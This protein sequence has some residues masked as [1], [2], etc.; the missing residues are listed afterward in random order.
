VCPASRRIGYD[1][2]ARAG[3]I[4]ALSLQLL[5]PTH[6]QALDHTREGATSGRRTMRSPEALHPHARGCDH[7]PTV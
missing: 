5:H 1:P 4:P 7:R 6:P 3:P 2:N